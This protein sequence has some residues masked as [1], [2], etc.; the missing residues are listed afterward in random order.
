MRTTQ[1]AAE[2]DIASVAALIGHPSR[3]A[4][5]SALIDG[6]SRPAG[7]LARFARV[8]AQTASAHL[9]KLFRGKLLA[10]VVQGRHHYYRLRDSSVA[11]LLESLA[12]MSTSGRPARNSQT[13]DMLRLKFARTCYGHLA[14]KLGV[15]IASALEAKQYTKQMDGGF[16]LTPAGKDWLRSIGLE[17][18]ILARNELVRGCL[19]WSERRFHLAGPIGVELAKLLF[20]KRWIARSREGRAVRITENGRQALRSLLDLRI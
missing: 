12:V 11:E 18:T 2:P 19:D 3:A 15:G 9:D 16:Q 20:D 1:L 4:M 10:V 7:E 8:S 17:P 5:L 14:G 6:R 13:E